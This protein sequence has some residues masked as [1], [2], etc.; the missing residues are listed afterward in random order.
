MNR[1]YD[2]NP[3]Q[4]I[5]TLKHAPTTYIAPSRTPSREQGLCGSC[6]AFSSIHMLEDRFLH[7]RIPTPVLSVA[8]LLFCDWNDDLVQ[9]FDR[10][11][12]DIN[13]VANT[14]C[15]GNTLLSAM[16][17]LNVFGTPSESCVPLSTRTLN[18]DIRD[19]DTI[20]EIPF[21]SSVTSPM[22]DLCADYDMYSSGEVFGKPS[23][24]YRAGA[25]Y[26]FPSSISSSL[27]RDL[28]QREIYTWGPVVS[29]FKV[30][31]HWF[32]F[33]PSREIYANTGQPSTYGMH[34]VE[35][36]GWDNENHYWWIRNTYGPKWG[37]QGLARIGFDSTDLEKNVVSCRIDRFKSTIYNFDE[38]ISFNIPFNQSER[39]MLR[40]LK[41]ALNDENIDPVSG[42]SYRTHRLYNSNT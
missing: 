20:R 31:E 13:K 40:N 39:V 9:R 19:M 22:E 33:N 32:T 35:I 7:A 41:Y 6:W 29:I 23:M 21:C 27:L 16:R 4:Y 2:I 28:I 37:I 17:Y 25:I 18:A 30:D 14:T 8:Q 12:E 3:Y 34:A 1:D 38:N 10:V 26:T 24:R 5:L 11:K 36:I 15:F 42:L